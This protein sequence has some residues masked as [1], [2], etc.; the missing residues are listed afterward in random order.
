MPQTTDHIAALH[1]LGLRHG[2]VAVSK[3]AGADPDWLAEV[4][5]DVRK[6]ARDTF[7]ER[8]PIVH[9][10]SL[11]GAGLSE[12]CRALAEAAS[13]TPVRDARAPFRFQ[14]DSAFTSPGFGSVAR[15]ALLR[16]SLAIGASGMVYPAG[17]PARVRALQAHG[18]RLDIAVAGMRLGVNL[19]GI[20]LGHLVRGTVLAPAQT[21]AVT[22]RIECSL[23]PAPQQAFALADRQRVRLHLGGFEVIG[24]VRVPG[25]HGPTPPTLEAM[26]M[27]ES[28]VVC[29][30]GDR[31]VLRRY[32]PPDILCGG[33][34][35]SPSP[36]RQRR[37]G[38]VSTQ[39]DGPVASWLER[40]SLGGTPA[41]VSRELGIAVEAA[42]SSLEALRSAGKCVRLGPDRFISMAALD[43]MRDRVLE[44]LRTYHSANPLRAGMPLGELRH[45]AFRPGGDTPE[46]S[47]V[48]GTCIRMWA[49]DR[50][51]VVEGPTVRLPD[52]QVRL[53]DRQQALLARVTEAYRSAGHEPETTAGVSQALGVPPSAVEAMVRIALDLG[54]LVRVA[55]G[56]YY[57][58]DTIAT[59][60]RLVTDEI[61]RNGSITAGRL[62]DL[63]GTSRKYAVPL[64]EYLDA[65]GFTRRVGDTRVLAE[66]AACTAEEASRSRP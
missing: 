30:S 65:S 5:A 14:V 34:V 25:S 33:Q 61:R 28:P 32:S 23:T 19:A 24:R 18:S 56:I 37:R 55:Q 43:A 50:L 36:P 4:D 45:A 54:Q 9:V 8:A 1:L 12:L 40:A 15:G 3:S 35:L 49:D 60:S 6:A 2:V 27:L 46:A 44:A 13:A 64:M 11:E 59:V 21:I 47:R 31:F 41:A 7:L 29:S 57:H 52:F 58:R 17:L 62:R 16:G 20:E 63:T 39:S 51:I 42:A 66:G 48:L 53:N 22:T 10:D 38:P 26:L